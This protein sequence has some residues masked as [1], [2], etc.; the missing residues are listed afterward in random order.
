MSVRAVEFDTDGMR[1]EQGRVVYKSSGRTQTVVLRVPS[2]ERLYL[3]V[4]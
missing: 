1:D 4:R 3:A 2:V